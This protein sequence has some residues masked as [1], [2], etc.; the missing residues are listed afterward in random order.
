MTCATVHVLQ[1]KLSRKCAFSLAIVHWNF[2]FLNHLSCGYASF[3]ELW[4]CFLSLTHAYII[5]LKIHFSIH[6]MKAYTLHPSTLFCFTQYLLFHS[7]HFSST[8]SLSITCLTGSLILSAFI[9]E[10]YMYFIRGIDTF[11]KYIKNRNLKYFL[12]FLFTY[13]RCTYSSLFLL[14]TAFYSIDFSIFLSPSKIKI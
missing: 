7:F 5:E 11:L 9:L 12:F 8:F 10:F 6:I 1:T 14:I 3:P 4:D 2:N 13:K